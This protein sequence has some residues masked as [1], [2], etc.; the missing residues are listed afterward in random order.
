MARETCCVFFFFFKS[1]I[2]NL[3]RAVI[4][5][6]SRPGRR[7]GVG[8]GDF[9]ISTPGF[10]VCFLENLRISAAPKEKLCLLNT[11]VR[12]GVFF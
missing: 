11:G 12:F 1:V 5:F 2:E 3:A 4:L 7:R 10:F 9:H 8:T 6:E